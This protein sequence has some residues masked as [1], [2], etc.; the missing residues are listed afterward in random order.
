[1]AKI[2]ICED[3]NIVALDIK[4]HLERF[5]YECAGIYT[6]AE[7]V[8]KVCETDK[9]DLVLMDI[10]LKGNMDGLD[11][12]GYIYKNYDVPV[13]ILTAYSDDAIISRAKNILPFGYI[14]KPFEERELKTTIEIALYRHQMDQKLR[15]SEERYRKLFEEAPSANFIASREGIIVDC[16]SEFVVL[17]GYKDKSSAIGTTI[18]HRFLDASTGKYS[19]SAVLE[20]GVR[21]TQEEWQLKKLDDTTIFVL[22]TLSLYYDVPNGAPD[23]QG[24]LIDITDRRE[25]ESQ[26]RQAQKMEAVGR[27]AGG[28]AHDFNNIITAIMGYSNLLAEDIGDNQIL[29][30]D[31]DGIMSSAHRA[32]DL[33]RQLLVFSR[34]KNIEAGVFNVNNAINDLEKMIRRLIREDITVKF[35]LDADVPFVSMDSNQFEEV[36]VNLIVNAR[37]AITDQGS[38]IIKSANVISDGSGK[39]HGIKK[40]RWVCIIVQDT[41]SGI[42]QEYLPH[43]FEPF[44]T[45]KGKDR[46]TGLGLS[47]VYTVVSA[48]EGHVA[49]ESEVGK[50]T[51]FFLYF[52]QV[53]NG[54]KQ[55][56]DKI[57]TLLPEKRSGTILLVED[58]EHLRNLLTRMLTKTGYRVLEA[59]NPGEAL[60][61][62]EREKDFILC[63]DVIMPYMDGYELAQRLVATHPAMRVLFMSGYQDKAA[64]IPAIPVKQSFIEKPFSQ[65]HLLRAL[66][67]L[68]K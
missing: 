3:E 43:I 34:K 31:V 57:V 24:F 4:R 48:A 5:G 11:A 68:E 20:G 44:F 13:V 36:I 62:A 55:K 51:T 61:L 59:T 35:F 40:G 53:T 50:G 46:G 27:L 66:D 39:N 10:Q 49:V 38:I 65:E 17:L 26:L 15:M 32:V 37:D 64:N 21:S 2:I 33:T 45:T 25:L 18:F 29:K 47:T 58:D 7:D 54:E 6:C 23:I 9:P 14:I 16:N 63:T 12:S 22:A 56:K 60:I 67:Y 30:E 19:F 52:P 28:V 41:G 42:R 1:M 8:L